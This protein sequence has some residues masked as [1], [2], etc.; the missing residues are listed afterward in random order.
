[1]DGVPWDRRTARF[2]CVIALANPHTPGQSE[3]R[4]PCHS[5]TPSLCHSEERSDE[6]SETPSRQ[7]NTTEQDKHPASEVTFLEGAVEGVIQYEPMGNNGFGYDPV[8]YLP[9]YGL[10]M[11]QLPMEEK[12]RISH[13]AQAAH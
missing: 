13:R 7:P 2:R 6:E 10:T 3:A 4:I 12:N 1:M 9:S 5:Q 11:A 8:F